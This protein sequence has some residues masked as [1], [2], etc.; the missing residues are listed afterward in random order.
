VASQAHCT[1][2][3]DDTQEGRV[4]A[5]RIVAACT[6]HERLV[7]AG[8][9]AAGAIGTRIERQ[10]EFRLSSNA[11]SLNPP[12]PFTAAQDASTYLADRLTVASKGRG[13][14]D[15]LREIHVVGGSGQGYIANTATTELHTD[16]VVVRQVGAQL[17]EFKCAWVG[18]QATGSNVAADPTASQRG[19]SAGARCIDHDVHR[20]CAVMAR[21]AGNGYRT[22]RRFTGIERGGAK[23]AVTGECCRVRQLAVPDRHRGRAI[24]AVRRMA[25][26][27]D[28]GGTVKLVGDGAANMV[29]GDIAAAE[30]VTCC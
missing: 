9:G 3:I 22:Y 23:L 27:A 11:V 7:Y 1:T 8:V 16:R 14:V 13:T 30:V 25:E 20:L 4:V 24:S 5:M 17:W 18:H 29:G 12:H 15:R 21:K 28:L 26:H 10:V 2:V 6:F 19:D